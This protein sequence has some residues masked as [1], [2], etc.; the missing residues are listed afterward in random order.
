MDFFECKEELRQSRK[1][2][3]KLNA[4]GKGFANRKKR[5]HEVQK[6]LQAK[7]E[8]EEVKRCEALNIGEETPSSKMSLKSNKTCGWRKATPVEAT[9]V[10]RVI[11]KKYVAYARERA[12]S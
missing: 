8:L 6:K 7:D 10:S 12:Q 3:R 4:G 11:R 5:T 2:E 9:P 1:K